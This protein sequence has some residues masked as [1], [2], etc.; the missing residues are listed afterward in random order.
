LTVTRDIAGTILRFSVLL[1]FLFIIGYETF[2]EPAN[3]FLICGVAICVLSV[4]MALERVPA[5]VAIVF[6]LL[7]FVW[8]Q[9]QPAILNRCHLAVWILIISSVRNCFL[10][11]EHATMSWG[12]TTISSIFGIAL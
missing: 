2:S 11:K 7:V 8:Y 5:H 9:I 1:L 12:F 4:F 3:D 10:L 6:I